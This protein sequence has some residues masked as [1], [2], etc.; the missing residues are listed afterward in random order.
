MSKSM[1]DEIERLDDGWQAANVRVLELG[2]ENRRLRIL[3]AEAYPFIGYHAHVPALMERV[4]AAIA[5]SNT[6]E[7]ADA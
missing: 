5:V 3:L 6:G 7:K 1:S 4:E 2:L